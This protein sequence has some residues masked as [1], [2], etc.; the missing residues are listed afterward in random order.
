[1]RTPLATLALTLVACTSAERPVERDAASAP[2]SVP[3]PATLRSLALPGA[4]ID[5]PATFVPLEPERID[6]LRAASLRAEPGATVEIVGAR[7]PGRL[8]SG[9]V[10]LQ[11][12]ETSRD[13]SPEPITVRALLTGLGED[14]KARII[15]EGLDIV[16]ADFVVREGALD[17]CSAVRMTKGERTVE[18]RGCIRYIV[19]AP[20]RLHMWSLQC[21]AD[22][23]RVEAAC[24]PILASRT[25][26]AEPALPADEL[27]PAN[28]PPPIAP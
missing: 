27:L 4:T 23:E 16:R 15:A 2:A 19:T 5:I 28:R 13:P 8:N 9:M 20:D 6:A 22:L 10:Y 11:R 3:A 18:V 14:L 7:D 21:M 1:M 26:T 25:F 17:G 12:S 24:A